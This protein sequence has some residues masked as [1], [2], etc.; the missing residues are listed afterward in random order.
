M[1]LPPHCSIKIEEWCP[2]IAI[3]FPAEALKE[4]ATDV[5]FISKVLLTYTRALFP[6]YE[7][8]VC[9]VA[10]G[11]QVLVVVPEDVPLRNNSKLFRLPWYSMWVEYVPKEYIGKGPKLSDSG[12]HHKQQSE[13][14][15]L[16]AMYLALL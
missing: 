3:L 7:K 1:I 8:I 11:I 10:V 4:A 6:L 9:S 5:L 14:L 13:Q 12:L 2:P 15:R 16:L